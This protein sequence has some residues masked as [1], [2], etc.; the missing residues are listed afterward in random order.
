MRGNSYIN[1]ETSR[2]SDKDLECGDLSPLWPLGRLV[3]KAEPRSAARKN[4]IR[5]LV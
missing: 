3:G 1:A 5:K 2:I 4:S